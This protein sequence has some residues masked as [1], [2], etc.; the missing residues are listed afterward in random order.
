MTSAVG[1]QVHEPVDAPKAETRVLIV[2]DDEL[3]R[4]AVRRALTRGALQPVVVE[5]AGDA[6][7]AIQLLTAPDARRRFDCVLLDYDL[8]G[9]TGIELLERL[10][11]RWTPVP[12]VMLTGATDPLTAAAS[13]KA[14]AT[15]FLTKDLISPDRLT[16]MIRGAI[17]VGQMEASLAEANRRLQE[18]ANELAQQ[19][20][21]SLAL[22]EELER[23]NEQMYAAKELAEA[24]RAEVETLNR[25][26]GILASELKLER[27]VQTVTD[28][29]TKLTGAQFGAFFY[30][31]MDQQ[32][33]KYTLYTLSGAP[34]EAFE[35]FGHPRPTPVFAPTFYGTSIVRS[36]DITKDP[37]YGQMP[38]HHGMP[39][40]HLPVRSY[41]AVPVMS[42]TGD[43]IGGLFF[44]HE[45][46]GV[47]TE[48]AERLTTGIAAWAAVAMDNAHL[49]EAE[50][51]A[52]SAAEQANKAKSEF[53]AN[54]SHELRTPLN[55]IGGYTELIV[56]G[57]RGPVTEAQMADLDRIKRNQRYLLSIINDI[58]NFAKLEAGRVQLALKTVSM[59]EAL[60]ALEALV[61]PQLEQKQLNYEYRCCD[62]SFTARADPERLQQ[63]LLNLLSNAIKFTPPGGEI[64]VLC[65]AKPTHMEVRV[66]DSGVGIPADKLDSI[67]EPF[68][69]LDR[70]QPAGNVGTGLGLAISRDLAR[71]M[72]GELAAK[73]TVGKGSTFVLTLPRA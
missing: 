7:T 59:N 46:V 26:G 16:Q 3:D 2:D 30:N 34:R 54:M 63:I 22:T 71:A 43:V 28:E 35:N 69:Q 12:V 53:L 66:K 27:I 57:I 62:P 49:Y 10:R 13:I 70:G 4:R 24:A 58:L 9:D 14:G 67:F 25:I 41:L 8:A 65:G 23:A 50:Q 31:V 15:D 55:A 44:G 48:R 45:E 1:E 21:E 18:Q 64:L 68:V 17:R 40:G 73:S 5:E 47:F 51:R 52:R 29:T 42:R 38:P 39:P 33:E 11:G 37:R 36:D 32:G 19:V 60:G 61:R 6:A 20:D 72:G 56:E